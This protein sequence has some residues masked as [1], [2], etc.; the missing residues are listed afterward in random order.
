MLARSLAQSLGC[1]FRRVQFT[2][3]ML[4]SDLTGVNVFNQ[5]SREFEFR[6]GPLMAQVVLADEINRATPKTQSALL[7]AMGEAQITVDGVTHR[8]PVPFI[9][10]ATQNPIEYQG[11]FPLPEA[12]LNRFL[13]R[14]RLGYPELEDEIH[15]LEQQQY[16]HP[17]EGLTQVASVDELREAQ[18]AVK[19]TF[20]SPAAGPSLHDP[21]GL[22]NDHLRAAR[23]EDRSRSE[24]ESLE[25]VCSLCGEGVRRVRTITAHRFICLARTG[26]LAA[27]PT[28]AAARHRHCV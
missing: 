23:A 4:P 18:E 17:L 1:S 25:S 21:R 27:A 19:A 14:I 3:D 20:I 2:P 12:Q 9:V 16:E 8:L 11:T 28:A 10:L 5:I 7:E 6:P 22:T 13:M 15:I 24:R 26:Y